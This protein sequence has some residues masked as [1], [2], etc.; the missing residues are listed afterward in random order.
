MPRGATHIMPVPLAA[1]KNKGLGS[2]LEA[3]GRTKSRLRIDNEPGV[4]RIKAKC[5]PINLFPIHQER[6]EMVTSSEGLAGVT[7]EWECMEC[8]YVEEG[9][10]ARRPKKCPECGAPASALEFFSDEDD[11]VIGRAVGDEYDVEDDEDDGNNEDEYE[12]EGSESV[13]RS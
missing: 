1:V 7:G 10:K 3:S 13:F 9:A 6:V 8:G 11:A 2:F 5:E 4:S 12:E